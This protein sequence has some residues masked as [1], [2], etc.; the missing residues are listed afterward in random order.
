MKQLVILFGLILRPAESLKVKQI[1]IF[2]NHKMSIKREK[3]FL[4]ELNLCKFQRCE[5]RIY[6]FFLLIISYNAELLFFFVSIHFFFFF[7]FSNKFN[8]VLLKDGDLILFL[9]LPPPPL[10]S[11]NFYFLN[12]NIRI[13]LNACE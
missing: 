10:I 11:L 5:N 9:E 1:R 6:Y 7:N 12:G 13:Y 3:V 2:Q 4:Y 8:L